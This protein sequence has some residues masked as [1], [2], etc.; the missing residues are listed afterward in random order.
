[1]CGKQWTNLFVRQK[2]F[3]FCTGPFRLRSTFS[4]DEDSFTSRP[5]SSSHT[6]LMRLKGL[7]AAR[8]LFPEGKRTILPSQGKGPSTDGYI[9]GDQRTIENAAQLEVTSASRGVHPRLTRFGD[10]ATPPRSH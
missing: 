7:H 5:T 3:I 9:A 4:P 2:D 1:M 10:L 6:G 8:I